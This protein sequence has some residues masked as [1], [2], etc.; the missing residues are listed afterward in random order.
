MLLWSSAAHL[1]RSQRPS[2]ACAWI[3]RD[4][5]DRPLLHELRP[6]T[7]IP[8]TARIL[9]GPSLLRQNN[10][11]SMKKGMCHLGAGRSRAIPTHEVVCW[12]RT[13][14]LPPPALASMHSQVQC[15]SPCHRHVL[16]DG[17]ATRRAI[18]RSLL[19]LE[20][21]PVRGQH[22]SADGARGGIAVF[23]PVFRVLESGRHPHHQPLSALRRPFAQ[24]ARSD[25]D[26]R[27]Q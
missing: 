15:H 17:Q 26:P 23:G 2:K 20:M 18:R 3:E 11:V 25:H 24:V 12:P 7:S 27:W 4:A 22:D 5:T 1:A 10:L 9:S 6:L 16:T 8:S 21:P 14:Y 13:P 19:T